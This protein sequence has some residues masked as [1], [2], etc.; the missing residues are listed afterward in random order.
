MTRSNL[1]PSPPQRALALA[2]LV[3]ALV[4]SLLGDHGWGVLAVI[5]TWLVLDTGDVR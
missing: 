2:I 3:L 4:A 1:V 5:T